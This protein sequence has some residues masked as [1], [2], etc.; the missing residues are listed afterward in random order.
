MRY[1]T[2]LTV[3]LA[4]A[5][6]G[7][8]GSGSSDASTDATPTDSVADVGA[9]AAPADATTTMDAADAAM[10][11]ALVDVPAPLDAVSD[12]LPDHSGDGAP[13]ASATDVPPAG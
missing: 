13:E 10:D 12:V 7:C 2:L 3:V 11:G 8:P 4:L 9:D 5:L 1:I 6:T